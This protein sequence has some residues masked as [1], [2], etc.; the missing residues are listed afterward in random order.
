MCLFITCLEIFHCLETKVSLSCSQNFVI[1]IYIE[2]AE[3][4]SSQ[5]PIPL[6]SSNYLSNRVFPIKLLL[7]ILQVRVVRTGRIARECGLLPGRLPGACGYL[8]SENFMGYKDL[9]AYCTGKGMM[10]FCLETMI[11][12]ATALAV[13]LVI[14]GVEKNPGPGV[15]AE[16]IKQG[17]CSGCDRNL[18]SVTQ[19][20]TCGCW[21][22]NSC[23]NG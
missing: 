9:M 23:G 21:F 12:C 18:T 14:G 22:N 11:L 5:I 13:L 17:L 15:E 16:K 19:C 8:D 3:L 6:L 1:R 20:D 4:I 7:N 10:T 2:I